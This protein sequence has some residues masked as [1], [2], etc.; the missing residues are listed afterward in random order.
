MV[1]HAY[2]PERETGEARRRALLARA[3]AACTGGSQCEPPRDALGLRLED[4]LS[5][6]LSSGLESLPAQV[7]RRIEFAGASEGDPSFAR[8]YLALAM[9]ERPDVMSMLCPPTK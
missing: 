7:I 2:E 5:R 9:S 4:A 8:Y 1:E 3:V 6:L